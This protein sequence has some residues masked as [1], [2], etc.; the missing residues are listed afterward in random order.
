MATYRIGE[1]DIFRTPE[2]EE[3]TS[4]EDAE[5]A[6]IVLSYNDDPIAIWDESGATLA[7]VFQQEVFRP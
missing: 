4:L 3:Y 5:A 7:I 1:C 2:P 6:A